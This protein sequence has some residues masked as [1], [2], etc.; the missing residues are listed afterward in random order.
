MVQIFSLFFSVYRFLIFES[1]LL[2]EAKKYALSPRLGAAASPFVA[3][4]PG[5]RPNKRRRPTEE[6]VIE[7]QSETGKDFNMP[8]SNL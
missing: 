1:L 8:R 3:D 4:I 7:D 2:P 6:V 5:D